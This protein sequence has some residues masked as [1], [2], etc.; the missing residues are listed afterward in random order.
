MIENDQSQHQLIDPTQI[1]PAAE[2]DERSQ[3]AMYGSMTDQPLVF[4]EMAAVIQPPPP[5]IA[6]PLCKFI[7]DLLHGIDYI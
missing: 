3:F 7:E 2:M 6:S 5:A 4:N 1:V